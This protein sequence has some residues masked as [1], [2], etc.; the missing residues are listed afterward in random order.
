MEGSVERERFLAALH[1]CSGRDRG[2]EDQFQLLV[3]TA[4]G[5][6]TKACSEQESPNCCWPALGIPGRSQFGLVTVPGGTRW[7]LAGSAV[8]LVRTCA[9][10]SSALKPF[11]TATSRMAQAGSREQ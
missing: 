7:T 1:I 6:T 11:C 5:I 3:D 10:V 4:L 2:N 9:T 8:R